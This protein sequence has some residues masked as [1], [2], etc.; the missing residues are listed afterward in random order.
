MEQIPEHKTGAQGATG[1]R[2]QGRGFFGGRGNRGGRGRGGRGG[3][4]QRPSRGFGGGRGMGGMGR[5]PH[6]SRMPQG[7]HAPRESYGVG[8]SDGAPGEV[9][10][11]GQPR[12]ERAAL[13]PIPPIAPGN[14]RIIPLGGVEEI[15]KNMTAIEIGDDIIVIDAGF[16]FKEE[17]TPGIDYILP[18]T[19]YL[20]ERKDRI[21]ALFITHGHLD[22][23]GGIPYVIDRIGYPPLYTRQFGAIMIQKRQEEF[24]HL[25]PLDM[26]VITG[27]ETIMAGKIKVRTFPISHTIPDSM[28]LIIDTPYG[29]IVFIEDV[30]VDNI[31]GVPTEEE[32]EQYRQFKDRNVLLLTMDSTSIEKAGFSLS[33][34][35]V[36]ENIDKFI[37]TVTGRLVIGT[38]ASQV[39]RIIAIIKAAEKYN[40]KVVVEG[41]SMKTNVEIIKHLKLADIKNIIPVEDVEKYPPDRIVM[42]VTGAQ[43]EE[44]AAL[45][46]M[47]TNQH[48][49]LKLRKTDTILLSSSIIPT[50]YNAV[51]KLKDNLYRTEARVITYLDSDIHASG[52]GNRDELKWIHEQIKYRFFVPLH[53]YHYFLRQ[54]AE[55]S[56]SLG[57]PRENVVVPDNG[58]VIEIYDQ[59]QKIR[60]L[61]EK[62]PANLVLVDG[63]AVGDAQEVVLRDRQSL[64]QDGM[65]TIV[66]VLDAQTGRLRKSPDIISRGFVYLRESQDLLRDAR[67]IIKNSIE[68]S[69]RGMNPIN[70]EIIK[71]NV[72]DA[73]SRHLFNETAKRP[74]VIPVL[75]TI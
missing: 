3:H 32:V 44:F 65:F 28:G 62:A 13:A 9:N 30:R 41:R 5:A 75:L 31:K 10:D 43:G 57:T 26:K 39:E 56:F 74:V 73:V 23:I 27:N 35:V 17:A 19:K 53:G 15:G 24:P 54:H 55:L 18:N 40:K 58:S 64:A 47:A 59:G 11:G 34:S 49:H 29:D 6:G 70:V 72:T 2:P 61:K 46:R 69:A 22:H 36:I 21:R 12:A 4:G 8:S 25:K 42:L 48:K 60:V 38:F 1:A 50:N 52:H 16:Q 68:D 63:F 51:I 33:E 71:A 14:I 20:E 37:K 67:A 45:M 7:A 66:A